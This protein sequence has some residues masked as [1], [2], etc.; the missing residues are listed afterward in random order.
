MLEL[1]ALGLAEGDLVLIDSAPLIYLVEAFGSDAPREADRR[2]AV[3]FFADQARAGRLRLAASAVAWTECLTGALSEG[4]TERTAAFRRALSDSALVVIAPV[5]VAVAEEAARLLAA[6]PDG[7]SKKSRGP[8]LELPD[9]IHVATAAVLEA[10]AILTNDGAW[11]EAVAAEGRRAPAPLA[12]IYRRMKV[13]S[14]DELAFS[15]D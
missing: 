13:L 9:A 2:K 12:R 14:V 6:V 7:A 8:R 5:D 4:E 3:R 1:E 15:A 11:A 10:A